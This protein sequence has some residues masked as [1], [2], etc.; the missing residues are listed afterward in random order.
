MNANTETP[1]TDPGPLDLA[2]KGRRGGQPISL[3]RRLFMKFTAF[4]GCA[5]PAAAGKA[6]A[7]DGIDGA[8]YEVAPEHHRH[9]V[10]VRQ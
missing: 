10:V 6:L 1:Q 7:A 5:D 8:L 3:D 2:E 4:G 9:D